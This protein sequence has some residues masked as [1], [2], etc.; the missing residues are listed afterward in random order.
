M[1]PFDIV[2]AKVYFEDSHCYKFRPVLC[3]DVNDNNVIARKMT[4][5]D[6]RDNYPGEYEL[7]DWEQEGL[8]KPTVVRMLKHIRIPKVNVNKV[9]GH[10]T[11]QDEIAVRELIDTPYKE[12]F[13]EDDVI[14]S[15]VYEQFVNI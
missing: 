13:N 5:G 2:S 10:L 14:D 8:N 1:K 4:S 11:P 9:I 7:K 6:K 12:S 15:Y 3:L